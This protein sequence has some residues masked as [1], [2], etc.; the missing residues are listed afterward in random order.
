MLHETALAERSASRLLRVGCSSSQMRHNRGGL[1]RLKVIILYIYASENDRR[2]LMRTLSGI[3]SN[4][5]HLN[6][7]Y[8]G[9][10]TR[11]IKLTRLI[12]NNFEVNEEAHKHEELVIILNSKK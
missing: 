1:Q 3:K 11:I 8:M 5:I 10:Q 12:S 9:K 4:K 7:K 6:L 2:V